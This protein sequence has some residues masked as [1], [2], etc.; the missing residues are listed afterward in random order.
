MVVAQ[1]ITI[2]SL[3]FAALGSIGLFAVFVSSLL[4]FILLCV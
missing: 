2:L 4:P 3:A 1:L